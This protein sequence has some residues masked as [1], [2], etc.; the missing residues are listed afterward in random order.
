MIEKIATICGVVTAVAAV[1]YT[2]R[3][4]F[5]WLYPVAIE[6]SYTLNLDGSEP[7]SMSAT[8][9]NRSQVTQYIRSC[10]VRGTFSRKYILV[11]HLRNPFLAPRLYQNIWYNGPVYSLMGDSPIELDSQQLVD[12][13]YNIYEHPLNAMHAPYFLV[14]ATLTS[15]KT[16]SSKKIDAPACWRMI[17]KRGR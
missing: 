9:T 10:T 17:G 2:L 5:F 15:G 13:K 14:K 8:I 12:L 7:D 16:V 6:P 4:F 11:R 3:K 1:I